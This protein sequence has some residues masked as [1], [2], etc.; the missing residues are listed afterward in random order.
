M[1]GIYNASSPNPVQNL[2]F[3]NQVRRAVN[4]PIGL[5]APKWI[6]K[7]G[8]WFLRTETELILKSRWVIP[9][10]LLRAGYVFKVEDVKRAIM[11][12]SRS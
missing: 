4:M 6:L 5:P 8:V 9:T 3:M 11:L 12:S 10:K 7:I 2:E 1:E